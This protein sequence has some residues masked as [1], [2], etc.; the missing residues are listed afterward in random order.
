MQKGARQK[1]DI[2]PPLAACASAADVVGITHLLVMAKRSLEFHHRDAACL[3]LLD[4]CISRLLKR[5]KL[6]QSDLGK[7]IAGDFVR[8]PT[9]V[10]VLMYAQAEA[11]DSLDDS[12]CADLLGECIG[13]LMKAGRLS[14]P[15]VSPGSLAIN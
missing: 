3:A 12:P 15:N 13:R 1:G 2:R 5:H 11:I 14:Q 8:F 10:H 9:V 7:V 6:S 4:R